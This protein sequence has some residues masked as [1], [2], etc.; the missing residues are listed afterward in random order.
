MMAP[1]KM[2]ASREPLALAGLLAVGL[3]A[4]VVLGSG[5]VWGRS[6]AVAA[7]QGGLLSLLNLFALE[8]LASRAVR[9]A[10]LGEGAAA[11]GL[12]AALSAKTTL[13][14]LVVA[15]VARAGAGGATLLPFALGLMV[16][17]FALLAA[18][19]R[20]ALLERLEDRA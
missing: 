17:V 4:A 2:T 3:A 11:A 10:Q 5:L 16:T 20:T 14:L 13:L 15:L 18:G 8:R 6:G 9:R 1:E 7:G 12:Q 19:L